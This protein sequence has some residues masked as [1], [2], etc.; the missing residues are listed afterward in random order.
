MTDTPFPQWRMVAIR[1]LIDLLNTLS[2]DSDLTKRDFLG[3]LQARTES[4][5]LTLPSACEPDYSEV[6]IL[7]EI[8]LL[9]IQ[10]SF[11]ESLL[12]DALRSGYQDALK[13]PRSERDRVLTTGLFHL[14]KL[15]RILT[16]Q[17]SPQ[18]LSSGNPDIELC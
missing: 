1:E 16:P 5:S 9:A 18:R 2:A 3:M 13:M 6:Q 17:A 11:S 12:F 10:S 7:A 14:R 4:L 8:G 15:Q